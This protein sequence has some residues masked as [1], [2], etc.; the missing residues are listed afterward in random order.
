[1]DSAQAETSAAFAVSLR[2]YHRKSVSPAHTKTALIEMHHFKG[3]VICNLHG[4]ETF[5]TNF[6][7]QEFCY[8]HLPRTTRFL[9][10]Q[11]HRKLLS[12]EMPLAALHFTILNGYSLLPAIGNFFPKQCHVHL[13]TFFLISPKSREHGS[14]QTSRSWNLTVVSHWKE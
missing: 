6:G 14:H 7:R 13:A 3:R 1:M 12:G 8:S 5:S 11:Y 2:Q 4:S 10:L 9:T